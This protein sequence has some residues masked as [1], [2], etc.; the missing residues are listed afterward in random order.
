MRRIIGGGAVLIAVIAASLFF[1]PLS[2]PSR[3]AFDWGQYS[4][5]PTDTQ[6]VYWVGHSLINHRGE[7]G[8][9]VP[10]QMETLAAA[11]SKE[12]QSFDHTLFGA[13]LSMLWRGEPISYSRSEPELV[14]RRAELE[15]RG[16]DYTSLVLTEGIP[17]GLSEK[18]EHSARYL[19]LF[20]CT[21]RKKSAEGRVYLYE[22]WNHYQAN[23]PDADYPPA[24][25]W[26]WEERQREDRVIWERIAD[27]AATGRVPPAE[28]SWH[29][30]R[31]WEDDFGTC[32][33]NE[34]IFLIPVATVIRKLA[35]HLRESHQWTYRGR[36]F[37]MTDLFQNPYVDWPEE[38]PVDPPLSSTAL[39]QR[40]ASLHK[41]DPENELDD[42]HPSALGVYIASLV[43]YSVLYRDSPLGLPPIEGLPET[44]NRELQRFVWD[45]V[46]E[47]V[48]TGVAR[49]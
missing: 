1:Y 6:R 25:Q 45:S 34:P 29:Y 26:N 11:K 48:R 43:S 8:P 49:H 18:R 24:D 28:F 35:A 22:G 2:Y 37:V 5:G 27:E 30:R 41:R 14:Q 4:L 3:R 46:L 33:L 10:E 17:V 38:W 20:S 7:G 16:G 32:E 13:P 31:F 21:F 42:V 47:D 12:Y 9:N 15:Q 19:Q 40:L 44:T 39:S 23:D 36:P